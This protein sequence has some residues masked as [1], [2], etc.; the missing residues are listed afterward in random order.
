MVCLLHHA[1]EFGDD[2]SK[3][4]TH[5]KQT[6]LFYMCF[7]GDLFLNKLL[8]IPAQEDKTSPL[9][10]KQSMVCMLEKCPLNPLLWTDNQSTLYLDRNMILQKSK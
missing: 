3:L 4:S 8:Q 5:S 1:W 7:C 9:K 6:F 10:G 2:Y